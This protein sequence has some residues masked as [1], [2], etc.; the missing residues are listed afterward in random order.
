[1]SN[2]STVLDEAVISEVKDMMKDKFPTMLSYF[3]EDSEMY[4]KQTEEGFA[5]NS[6]E[7]IVSPAHTLKSSSKQMGAMLL[8]DIAK[9]IEANAREIVN[10]NGELDNLKPRLPELK[11]A[12]EKTLEA[13]KSHQN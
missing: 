2:Q 1:M 8:S 6:A 3:I 11:D 10:G 12:L 5:A 9:D 7:E 13:L 4:V